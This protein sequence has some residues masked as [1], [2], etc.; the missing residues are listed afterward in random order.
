MSSDRQA[1]ASRLHSASIHLLR[2]VRAVDG[3]SGLSPARLSALSVL[4]FGGPRTIGELARN[5]GVRS[6]TMTALVNQLEHDGFVRRTRGGAADQRHVVVEATASGTR[7]MQKAQR[8]RLDVLDA[9]LADVGD[10]ELR[11][12]DRA[13]T[14]IEAALAS[15]TAAGSATPGAAGTPGRSTPRASRPAAGTDPGRGPGRRSS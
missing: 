15:T 12:L 6:P 4:V 2:H 5:E 13:A 11:L 8:R 1:I 7:L 9:L 14:L 3:E 10:A